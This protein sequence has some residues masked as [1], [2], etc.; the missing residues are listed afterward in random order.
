MPD[1]RVLFFALVAI[2]LLA[3]FGLGATGVPGKALWA[4]FGWAVDQGYLELEGPAGAA[5]AG[6][7]G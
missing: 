7:L 6:A 5:L 2:L 1:R 3:A 4:A